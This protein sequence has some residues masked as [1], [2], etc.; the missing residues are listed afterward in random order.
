MNGRTA[1]LLVSLLVLVIAVAGCDILVD[2]PNPDSTVG[3]GDTIPGIKEQISLTFLWW[4]ESEIAVRGPYVSGFYT[5]TARPG[6]KFVILALEF[7]N[8]G[9]RPEYTPYLDEGE[10]YTSRGYFYPMWQPI[11]GIWAEEY[12]PRESTPQEVQE[13]VGGS[14]GGFVNL[15]PEESVTGCVVFEIP[16]DQVPLS[17]QLSGVPPII[18]LGQD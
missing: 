17:V 4:R 15:L 11:G 16:E 7:R 6:M 12:S 5:F 9:I 8:A 10:I 18:S 1:S 2:D 3:M 13:F 14:S